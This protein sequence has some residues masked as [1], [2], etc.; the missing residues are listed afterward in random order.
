MKSLPLYLLFSTYL[1]PLFASVNQDNNTS[2]ISSIISSL[3][4]FLWELFGILLFLLLLGYIFWFIRMAWKSRNSLNILPMVNETGEEGEFDGIAAGVDDILMENLQKIYQLG[5]TEYIRSGWTSNPQVNEREK[6]K[7]SAKGQRVD[8]VG[9]GSLMHAQQFGDISIGPIKIPL[10]ALL[11]LIFNI[12]GGKNLSG[13]LQK[14]GKINTIV[15]RLE[16]RLPMFSFGKSKNSEY[17]KVSWPSKSVNIDHLAAGVPVVIEEL[18]YR[19][20]LSVGEEIGTTH[21]SAY[22]WFLKGYSAFNDYDKNAT[23]QD[24]LSDAV[25]CYRQSIY[26]DPYFAKAH[27]NLGV[28][29]DRMGEDKYYNDAIFRYKKAIGLDPKIIASEAHVSL[30]KIY[31]YTFQESRKALEELEKA[32]KFDKN[33]PD[34]FNLKGLVYLGKGSETENRIAAEWFK[35]AKNKC[36]EKENCNE[37][38]K[39]LFL[40]NYSVASYYLKEFNEAQYAGEEALK[41]LKEQEDKEHQD[42]MQTLGMIHIQKARLKDVKKDE[43]KKAFYYFEKALGLEPENRDILDGYGETLRETGKLEEAL[44]IQR[45]LIRLWPE[46]SRGYAEIAKT[47]KALKRD[48]D[49]T[50]AYEKVEEIFKKED[51]TEILDA[52][53]SKQKN[54]QQTVVTGSVLGGYYLYVEQNYELAVKWYEHIVSDLET[55]SYL[56]GPEILHNYGVALMHYAKTSYENALIGLQQRERVYDEAAAK[57]QQAQMLYDKESQ[58]YEKAKCFTDLTL[59]LEMIGDSND[60]NI[61]YNSYQQA[62]KLYEKA[63]YLQL[64]SDT[65]VLNAEYIMRWKDIDLY[66]LARHECDEAIHLDSSNVSAYHSKGNTYFNTGDDTNAIAQYEKAVELNYNQPSVHYNLG[67]SYFY[68]KEYDKAEKAFSTSIKLSDISDPKMVDTYEK[69]FS[70]LQMQNRWTEAVRR[71][72]KIV[73]LI[74]EENSYRIRLGRALK[75]CNIMDEAAETFKTVLDQDRENEQKL[76]HIALYHLADIYAEQGAN[77]NEAYRMVQSALTIKR[78]Q[79]KKELIKIRDTKLQECKQSY[80]QLFKDKERGYYQKHHSLKEELKSNLIKTKRQECKQ[81]YKQSFKENRND[82]ELAE[83][84]NTLGWLHYQKNQPKKARLLLEKTLS[85]S[86][87]NPK[88]HAR[89]AYAYEKEAKISSDTHEQSDLLEKAK[90]QWEIV[91]DLPLDKKNLRQTAQE[92]LETIASAGI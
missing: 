50:E 89:L 72:R 36:K 37:N 60:F 32:E 77:I 61:T 19:I 46:Y 67:L 56:L 54:R 82:K 28:A 12:F 34:I 58:A 55:G 38:S 44:I 43:Y 53:E 27:Y 87:S 10:R 15:L 59:L 83:I 90:V 24:R 63:G 80:K 41:I 21:W 71:F 74:P 6:G 14:Y 73:N 48:E 85:H 35:K 92:H 18:A 79:L 29:L 52:L 7:L 51:K 22:K 4:S 2:Q 75:E 9:S 42:L 57:L 13:A 91:S 69:L 1:S 45:R 84:N 16:T 40:Y 26:I 20:I 88:W 17:F 76:N 25:D 8:V 86:M 66:P 64:A 31:W 62:G 3:S 5:S 23:R 70:A 78:A 49:E 68:T 11:L 39:A 30:A 47:L 33:M 81:L 65:H